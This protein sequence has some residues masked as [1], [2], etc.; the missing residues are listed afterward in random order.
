MKGLAQAQVRPTS[1]LAL[2]PLNEEDSPKGAVKCHTLRHIWPQSLKEQRTS[3][4]HGHPG[5]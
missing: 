1:E 3:M 2:P 4:R 5:R